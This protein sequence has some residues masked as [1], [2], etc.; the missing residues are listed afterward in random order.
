MRIIDAHTHL[1]TSFNTMAWHQKFDRIDDAS[2]VEDFERIGIDCIVTAPHTLEIGLMEE[3]NAWTAKAAEAFPGKI[4]GYMNVSPT[5]GVHAVKR[6]LEKYSKNPAF[7]GIKILAGYFGEVLQPEFQY[8]M[9]FA[10]ETGCPILFHEWGN[11][12]DRKGFEEALKTRHNMKLIIAHQGG[13]S[14]AD[15]RACAPII[16]SYENAYMELCGSLENQYPVEGIIDLVGE[17]KV[18]FGTDLI[19]LD[20]KYE[21]GRVMFAEM[22]DEIKEKVFSLNYLKLLET[23]QLGKILFRD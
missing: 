4:Y 10:D 21:L 8:A 19:D 7:V 2:I 23:S 9:D 20:P 22:S 11:I 1:G 13:G 12:P 6:Q 3:T 17:D 14:A 18:I 15:T 5:D 16:T